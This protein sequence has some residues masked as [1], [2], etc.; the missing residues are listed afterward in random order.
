MA[1][2]AKERSCDSGQ[3]LFSASREALND[4]AT[5]LCEIPK[6]LQD[7]FKDF[8]VIALTVLLSPAG[9]ASTEREKQPRKFYLTPTTQTGSEALTACAAGYRVPLADE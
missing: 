8:L 6:K 7:G 4:V 9:S 5:R 2:A 1:S 3:T